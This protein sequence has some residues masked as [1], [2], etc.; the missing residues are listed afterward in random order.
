MRLSI[1]AAVSLTLVSLTMAQPS[2]AAMKVPVNI[3]AQPLSQALQTLAR[4][5]NFQIVYMYN[6]LQNLRSAGLVGQFTAD[7]ALLQLLK[8]TGLSY[9]Y[10]DEKTVTIVPLGRNSSDPSVT[11]TEV[12]GGVT[13]GAVEASRNLAAP[14]PNTDSL[15]TQLRIAQLDTAVD[16]ATN[17]RD[18]APARLEEVIVTAE[19]REERLQDVPIPVTVLSAEALTQANELRVQDYY[20][21]VP[22][23][24]MLFG[25]DGSVPI[26]AI[27]GITNGAGGAPTVGIVIDDVPYGSANGYDP[28]GVPDIDPGDLKSVE[29]LRGPQGTLYGAS[30]LGGL[31]KFVTVD[32][33]TDA[34]R[35]RIQGGISSLFNGVAPGYNFRGSINIPVND[36]TALRASAFRQVDGGYI[37]NIQTGQQGINRRVSEGS[38]LAMLWKASEVLSL[39][40][41]ALLQHQTRDGTDASTVGPGFGDL[42]IRALP[43]TYTSDDTTQAYSATLSAKLGS[44]DLVSLTGYNIDQ[45]RLVTDLTRVSGGFFGTCGGTP[46]ADCGLS[47]YYL[48]VAGSVLLE[49]MSSRRFSQEL[50]LS[51]PLGPRVT[52]LLG[53]FYTTERYANPVHFSGAD[54][55]TGAPGSDF[56]FQ[57][58]T[59]RYTEYAGFTNLRFDITDRL[60]VQVGGRESRNSQTFN[61]FRAGPAAPV[62]YCTN[63]DDPGTCA[64]NVALRAKDTPFTYLVTPQYKVSPDLML[65]SRLATG[66]R[67]GGANAI[68]VGDIPCQFDA[69]KT[70]NYE[71]GVKGDFLAHALSVDASVYRIDWTNI[72]VGRT[73]GTLGY[74]VNAGRARSQGIELAAQVRPLRGLTVS[75]WVA[76]DDAKFGGGFPMGDAQPGDRLPYSSR[77]SGNLSAEEEFVLSGLLTGFVGG[78][79]SFVG[80]RLGG[81]QA[82]GTPRA[83]LPAYVQTD[84]QAGLKYATWTITAFVNNVTD[85]R[86][87]LA[88]S[89]DYQYQ[90]PDPNTYS[91]IQPRTVGLNVAK[92]F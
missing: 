20:N 31:L 75:A 90:F 73:E 84:V 25:G 39:K 87:V 80:D 57:Y 9:H 10:L 70:R 29:V 22:G 13:P 28:R 14:S 16:I 21:K 86:G 89:T 15:W 77:L 32:P 58:V 30:T 50:R 91:F 42:Q 65:Y 78:S 88:G 1:A 72:V 4:D 82:P 12:P 79:A 44:A 43:N 34:L 17:T 52:W 64:F 18:A 71:L 51:V 24:N 38:R 45:Y 3:P 59:Q 41:S 7:E 60:N 46:S 33:A 27:R 56:L 5:R 85:K 48:G 61:T 66:Y 40:V 54:V 26:L 49:T 8:G 92:S 63:P 69:E 23:L 67:P 81:I 35:G 53:G 36:T 37:D 74:S 6:D 76:W 83:D 55:V 19:K 62:F 47:E 11:S 68:C 2:G